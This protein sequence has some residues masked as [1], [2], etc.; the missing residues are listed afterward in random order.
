MLEVA[1]VSYINTRP[2]LDGFDQFFKPEE[3]RFHLLPPMECA[4]ALHRGDVDLSLLP[5]GALPNF[6]KVGILPT[7]CIGGNGPVE[8]VFL[9]SQQ[10]VQSLERVIL[11]RHSR[12]SNGLARILLQSYWQQTVQYELPTEKHFNRIEGSTGGVVIGDTA[13]RIRDRFA[14]QYDLSEAWRKMTGLSFAFAIWA[15]RP[16]ALSAQQISRLESAM[17][18]GVQHL[19]EAAARWAQTFDFSE[20]FARHYLTNCIDYRFDAPKH[21]AMRVYLQQLLQ[22]PDLALQ[23]V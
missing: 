6:E 19:P 3:A 7:Y 21:R 1:L 12:S 10:P 8:S 5:V 20:D 15:Y 17:A 13:I 2:F 23:A 11:D 14:Y 16:D 9:L 18:W 4:A 22:L